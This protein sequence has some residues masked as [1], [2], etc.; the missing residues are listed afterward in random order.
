M[1]FYNKLLLAGLATALFA[2]SMAATASAN[3]LRILPQFPGA[4]ERDIRITWSNLTFDA[5]G[6]DIECEVT[7]LGSFHS[8]TITKTPGALVGNVTSAEVNEGACVGGVADA[9]EETLPWH[10]RFVGIGGTLPGISSVTIDLIGA[11]FFVD[12]TAD[13]LAGTTAAEPGRGI[14][15]VEARGGITG[16]Q[17]DPTRTIDL[18]GEFLCELVGNGSFSGNATVDSPDAERAGDLILIYLI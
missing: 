3:N 1:R 11:A 2:M 5:A 8:K 7:L 12:S 13:C 16:L 10:V 18:N 17:A 15:S 4:D 14:A 6:V 9:L